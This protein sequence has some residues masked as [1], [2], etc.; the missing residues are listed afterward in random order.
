MLGRLRLARHLSVICLPPV[1]LPS[2]GLLPSYLEH[3]HHERAE[4]DRAKRRGQRTLGGARDRVGSVV[5]VEPP[6]R[7]R[8]RRGHVHDIDHDQAAPVE[9]HQ[10]EEVREG[11][12][13]VR[14]R[15][16]AQ[17]R[18][19]P[20]ENPQALGDEGTRGHE[21]KFWAEV[22]DA[23]ACGT[24]VGRGEGYPFLDRVRVEVGADG[25]E[26]EEDPHHP[27]AR[28]EVDDAHDARHKHRRPKH[29]RYHSASVVHQKLLPRGR[30]DCGQR[31]QQGHAADHASVD[32][33]K[34]VIGALAI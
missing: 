17:E 10:H 28:N 13:G 14:R 20:Y 11:V 19:G 27:R 6:R 30:E 22:L 21:R 18:N 33:A 8:A 24:E 34:I 2:P 3:G 29:A 1:C 23:D 32:R 25:E 31:E 5:A 26:D 7:H 9:A 16:E 4:A 12:V 15:A